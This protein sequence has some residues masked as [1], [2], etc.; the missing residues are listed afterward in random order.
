MLSRRMIGR[1]ISPTEISSAKAA[2]LTKE[3]NAEILDTL[4]RAY[5]INGKIKEAVETERKALKLEPGNEEVKAKLEEYKI[6]MKH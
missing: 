6:G 1:K 2:D 4:A 5:S 3:K